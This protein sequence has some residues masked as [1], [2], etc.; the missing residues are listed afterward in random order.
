MNNRLLKINQLQQKM[1]VAKSLQSV[2]APPT[3]WIKAIRT[4]IGMSAQQLANKLGIR[5]QSV[6]ELEQRE[7]EKSITLKSL[8][9]AAQALDMQ[10]VYALIPK[11]G[12][13]E[14]L[15]EKKATELAKEIVRRTAQTMSLEDQ[16]N[17]A[18][19]L[20][21]AVEERKNEIIQ[22]MPKALWD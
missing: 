1:G 5:Q 7:K 3:G 19:R 18:T 10:V 16:R 20:Q 17:S 8:E 14:A 12:S 15:I 4:A 2:S 6:Q 11:D 21:Q 9:E 13:L 22:Q